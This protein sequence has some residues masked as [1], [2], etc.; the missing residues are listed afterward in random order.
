[1]DK[2]SIQ[3]QNARIK[4]ELFIDG[5]W[6]KGEG[7]EPFIVLNPF[8]N[9]AIDPARYWMQFRAYCAHNDFESD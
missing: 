6:V 2:S 7:K 4:A 8:D 5:K 3:N 1:M 9:S